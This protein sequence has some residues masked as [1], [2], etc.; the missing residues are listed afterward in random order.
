MRSVKLTTLRNCIVLIVTAILSLQTNAQ[1]NSPYSRYGLGDLIPRTHIINRS[2]GGVTAAYADPFAINNLNPASYA[3]FLT[4][5]DAKTRKPVSSRVLFDVGI[6]IDN[7]TLKESNPPKKFTTANPG[8]SYVQVGIP[9][10]PGWGLSFGLKQ[11][12]RVSYKIAKIEGLYDPVSGNYID[13]AATEFKGEGGSFLATAGTGVTIFKKKTGIREHGLSVGVNIGYL[14]GKKESSTKRF[15]VDDTLSYNNSNHTTNTGFGKFY[16]DAGLMYKTDLKNHYRLNLGVY[17]NLKQTLNGD[18]DITRETFV[19]SSSGDL[20]LDSVYIQKGI[21]G[22]IIYPSSFGAGFTFER[23][24]DFEKKRYAT[25][26]VGADFTQTNWNQYRYFG[27][28]DSVQKSWQFKVGAQIRPEPKKNYFSNIAYRAGF[29]FGKDY[30]RIGKELPVSGI[31]LGLGLPVANYNQNA[32][33]Q[34]SLVNIAFEYAKRG[35]NSNLLRENLF[36]FSVGFSLT[37][38]WFQKKKYD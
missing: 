32:R 31:T 10:K 29:F 2:M 8:F 24:E 26:L 27:S 11:V 33:G 37:D 5:I 30:V 38:I 34:A 25:W 13:S 9:V 3:S 7:H 6:S 35:N 16:L 15:I 1:D 20:Q 14:F 21:K 22:K 23:T 17:G 28:V 4:Y 36:R 18:Q 19:R 12:S